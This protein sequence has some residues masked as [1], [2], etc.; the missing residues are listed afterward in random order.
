MDFDFDWCNWKEKK[1]KKKLK[2][3]PRPSPKPLKG[4]FWKKRRDGKKIVVTKVDEENVYFEYTEESN[5]KNVE[6]NLPC[7]GLTCFEDVFEKSNESST[8]K[9]KN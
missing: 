3:R 6:H 8:K 1:E 7:G 4:E 5:L 2:K 9:A